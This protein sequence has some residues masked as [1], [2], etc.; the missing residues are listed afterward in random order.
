[1]NTIRQSEPKIDVIKEAINT[2]FSELRDKHLKINAN[3]YVNIRNVCNSYITLSDGSQLHNIAYDLD[4]YNLDQNLEPALY[5]LLGK[6]EIELELDT[7]LTTILEI[8]TEFNYD[9]I[10]HLI[11]NNHDITIV[12][13]YTDLNIMFSIHYYE[14]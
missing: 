1:M 3:N 13:T 4:L 14:Q 5:E 8:E 9:S 6:H 10:S 11:S 7:I 2:Y 12:Y